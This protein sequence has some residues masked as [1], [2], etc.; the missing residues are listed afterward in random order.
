MDGR[1]GWWTQGHPEIWKYEKSQKGDFIENSD[2]GWCNSEMEPRPSI[3]PQYMKIQYFLERVFS[4][5]SNIIF[6]DVEP[7]HGET[8]KP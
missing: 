1:N 3:Y 6:L 4:K 2:V 7:C 8:I 5:V